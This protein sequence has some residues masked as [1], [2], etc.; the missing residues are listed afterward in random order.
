MYY[1]LNVQTK[2]CV[3]FKCPQRNCPPT[4]DASECTSR[5]GNYYTLEGCKKCV[6]CV[7]YCI[8]KYC[9]RRQQYWILQT[10][11]LGQSRLK[12]KCITF[13][14]LNICKLIM[15]LVLLVKL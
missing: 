12:V 5:L 3:C 15:N 8:L 1:D 13:Q 4:I 2:A 7:N 11:T 6:N 14:E 10:E 9:S